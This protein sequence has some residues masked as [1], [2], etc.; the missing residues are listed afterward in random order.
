MPDTHPLESIL[1]QADDIAGEDGKAD[2]KTLIESFD[3]RAFGPV[4]TLLGLL[5]VS[6]VGAIPGVPIVLAAVVILFAGQILFGRTS[7]WLPGFVGEM[8]IEEE[9]ISSMQDKANDWLARID[10]L[11]RPRI[12][13][14]AGGFARR[15]AACIVILLS[16]VMMPLEAVPFAVAIPAVGITL[17]GIG[18]TARDGLVMLCGFTASAVAAIGIWLLL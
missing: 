6:P 2:L 5:A 10:G 18:L 15:I 13:W 17:F 12:E 3:D 1:D 4:L 8:S 11:L 9:K 14:A 7:P 16:F